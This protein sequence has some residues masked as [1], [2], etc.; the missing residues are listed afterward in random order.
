[1]Q[2]PLLYNIE[3]KKYIYL[4]K[5]PFNKLGIVAIHLA[6]VEYHRAHMMS[7]EKKKK[8]FKWNATKLLSLITRK[9]MDYVTQ[10][11]PTCLL[12]ETL[13]VQRFRAKWK[14]FRP[15]YAIWWKPF[16]PTL[17]EGPGSNFLGINLD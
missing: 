8:R 3:I 16:R 10:H 14:P 9:K 1:M 6:K 17:E 5:C 2:S 13:I 7:M 11:S 12:V 4:G 15:Q